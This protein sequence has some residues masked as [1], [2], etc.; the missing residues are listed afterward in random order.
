MFPRMHNTMPLNPS[1]TIRR[2]TCIYRP[3]ALSPELITYQRRWPTDAP[4]PRHPAITTIEYFQYSRRFLLGL[5][6]HVLSSQTRSPTACELIVMRLPFA[7]WCV[8]ASFLSMRREKTVHPYRNLVL[9]VEGLG[10]IV[11]KTY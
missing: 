1:N 7:S 9:I 3:R 4:S 11:R 6:A 8:G 2:P 10:G 5:I